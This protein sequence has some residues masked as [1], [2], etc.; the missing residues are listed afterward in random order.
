MGIVNIT[1]DSFSDGDPAM[2]RNQ[3]VQKALRLLEDGAAIVD[4]GAESTRPGAPCVPEEEEVRRLLP[5]IAG[6]RKAAPDA[7]ISADTRKS[8]V[9]RAAME[10]GCDILNDVS[11]LRFD[12]DYA[13]V[14]AESGAGL[15]LMYS[16]AVPETMQLE[17]NIYRGQDIVKDVCQF[18][19]QAAE[20][21]MACGVLRSNIVL[22]PG[23][24]FGMT[25]EQC[26]ILAE[27]FPQ[28]PDLGFPVLI[29]HSRKSFLGKTL[30]PLEREGAT[31]ELSRQLAKLD[32]EFLRLH[33]IQSWRGF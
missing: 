13:T 23:L 9:A 33:S 19:Q 10:A 20:K 3:A 11:G 27:Q 30:S 26:R 1:P 6:I 31:K 15:I 28:V 12:P 32:V 22:D 4:V 7:V 16:R 29:G 8:A 24:G 2:D 17:E 18:L 25:P 21:A 14:A 5:V